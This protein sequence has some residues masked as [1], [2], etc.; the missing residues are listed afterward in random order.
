MHRCLCFVLFLLCSQAVMSQS[1]AELEKQLD[2]L[3]SK[4]EKSEFMIGVGYGNNPAYGSKVVASN[5]DRPIVMKTFVTPTV[6]YYHKSGFYGT[7]SAYYLFDAIG[8]PWFE[9]DF[10]AGYDYSKNRNFLTGISYTRYIFSD[11]S[12][13]PAT[14]IN[15][16]L[17]A[18]FYYRKW[19]VQPGISL[20]FGWG[21]KEEKIGPAT[22]NV[23]GNDWNIVAAV[24]H[25]FIFMD[26]IKAD[27]A[28][29]ITPSFG[30]TMGTAHY[31]SNLKAFQYISRSPKLK[32][33]DKQERPE[34]MRDALQL[35]S[36]NK[37][38]FEVRALDFTLNVSYV[39]G[40]FTIA[41]SYTVFRPFQGTDKSLMGYFTARVGFSIK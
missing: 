2:S 19:W 34:I 35:S 39:I 32:W 13:V 26:V 29:L 3:L 23:S 36:S 14:P 22:R 37:T 4:R 8:E 11:S 15:N 20:D 31:Y 28:F 38:G 30:L 18:Y 25:P 5:E 7:A 41:P 21:S 16:E 6:G 12:D 27:D 17:F 1:L 33:D 40:K 9:W 10:S 24:R